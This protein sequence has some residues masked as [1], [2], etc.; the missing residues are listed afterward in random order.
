MKFAALWWLIGS[1]IAHDDPVESSVVA[2]SLTGAKD[3]ASVDDLY[4]CAVAA[5]TPCV[6]VRSGH[7][8]SFTHVMVGDAI[9]KRW[10]ITE[11]GVS[12]GGNPT[13]LYGAV[14]LSVS[15]WVLKTWKRIGGTWDD[16]MTVSALTLSSCVGKVSA[17]HCAGYAAFTAAMR[18]L[19]VVDLP[20]ARRH[21]SH[22]G[23]SAPSG[24][25][26]GI[27]ALVTAMETGEGVASDVAEACM[28]L[29]RWRDPDAPTS[30]A[31]VDGQDDPV[32]DAVWGRMCS[33]LAIDQRVGA[34]Q[35]AT[36]VSTLLSVGGVEAAATLAASVAHRSAANASAASSPL[37]TAFPGAPHHLVRLLHALETSLAAPTDAD[38]SDLYPSMALYT[39]LEASQPVILPHP[40]GT[41]EWATAVVQTRRLLVAALD[42]CIAHCRTR[43]DTHPCRFRWTDPLAG[44]GARGLFLLA[45]Q[46]LGLAR[47]L[48]TR[49][50]DGSGGEEMWGS[51]WSVPA[52]Y[53][54]LVRLSTPH[55]PWASQPS[56]LPDSP[57]FDDPHSR[58]RRRRVGFFSTFFY[59]HPVGRL[60]GAVVAGLDT[61]LLEVYVITTLPCCD[62]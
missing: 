36:L 31:I 53:H 49:G 17:L 33:F 15:P 13:Y 26:G 1:A 27:W 16:S 7:T 21:L 37:P 45:Y 46:G 10:F 44:N 54:E 24:L 18:A 4:V 52:R 39:L 55:W 43:V 25:G 48:A 6:G 57:S 47:A 20:A 56:S 19:S 3:F 42:T 32:R 12:D 8:L 2:Y 62:P 22:I 14:E 41:D 51:D 60:L 9:Q 30:D 5:T 23:V 11:K 38:S 61:T 59:A 58:T 50:S 28:F 29:Q 40:A 34:A 35:A